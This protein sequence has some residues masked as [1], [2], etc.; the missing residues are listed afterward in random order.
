[1]IPGPNQVVEST[2]V[3][4]CGR[5]FKR[6]IGRIGHER[7]CPKCQELQKLSNINGTHA[8]TWVDGVN[9]ADVQPEP[10]VYVRENTT[11]LE[12]RAQLERKLQEL[13]EVRIR[14]H[15]IE[16]AIARIVQQLC[17]DLDTLQEDAE[18]YQQVKAI[19]GK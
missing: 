19:F 18:K 12:R 14:E 13:D 1:M 16:A 9:F 15:E 3:S 17:A 4:L 11:P 6:A 10:P 5:L 7:Y 8:G 2:R